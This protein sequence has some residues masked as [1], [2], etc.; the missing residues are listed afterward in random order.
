MPI[1][2][3]DKIMRA[4]I[5]VGT[6]GY[7]FKDWLGTVY[8]AKMQA[9]DFLSYYAKMFDSAEINFT[10]YR[11]PSPS[12]FANMLKKV[13]PDFTFIVKVPREMTHNRE[14]M[15]SVV[16]PFIKGIAPL[17]EAGQLGG[18]LA[19]FPYSFKTTSEG[20]DHLKR[21]ANVFIDRGIPLNVEFRHD[22]WYKENVYSTLKELGLGFVNVDLPSLPDLPSASNV[23]TSDVAYYRLHGRNA[24]MWWH[25]PT[26]SHRYDYLYNDDQL[27]KWAT[28]VEKAAPKAKTSYIFNNNCHLG[29]SVV[30]ALHLHQRLGLPKPT[31]PPG[32]APEMF[33]P[34]TDELIAQIKARIVQKQAEETMP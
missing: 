27:E 30:N 12:M 15:P 33:E 17:V 7:S 2:D 29:Q 5:R 4:S 25:H 3:Y 23:V 1:L 26:P 24:K 20:I 8:P 16:S 28:R 32:L 22:S 19:Q 34:S 9:G 13:P 18:L 11:V 10:Y 14:K 31:L 21:L 6:S